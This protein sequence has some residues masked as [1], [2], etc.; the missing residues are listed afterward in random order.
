VERCAS[1]HPS[2]VLPDGS[3]DVDG[4]SHV[5]GT[6]DVFTSH[7][8]N[9]RAPEV[10]GLAAKD[11]LRS[12]QTCHG[13]DFA[14][15]TSTVSCN[16]CHGGAQW[17]TNCTF[18]HGDRVTGLAAPPRGPRGETS[19]STLAVGAHTAHVSAGGM[20]RAFSCDV[21]HA[22]P[23]NLAHIDGDSSPRFGTLAR[24]GG[25]APQWSPATASCATTY[26]HGDTLSGGTV[27]APVWTRVDGTQAACGTCHS[28]PPP[29][30]HPDSSSCG[31][32]HTGYSES[33]VNAAVHVDG[34]VQVSAAACGAC[35]SIPPPPPHVQSQVCGSCHP[36]YTAT[37]VVTRTHIDGQVQAGSGACGS[38]HLIPPAAPHP[39]LL[40]CGTCHAG[41]TASSANEATHMDGQIQAAATCGSC[42]GIPPAAP[43]PQ[44]TTCGTCHTGY[45]ATAAN[46]ATHL[47]GRV[48]A[49]LICGTCHAIPPG[50]PHTPLTTCGTCHPGY[51]PSSANAATHMDGQ[52]QANVTCGSCHGI[53]P[54][55]PH[56][57]ITTCGTCHP[58]Y[59]ATAVNAATH[60]DGRVQSDMQ[61]G[62]CHSIPPSS[63]SHEE[64]E[65]EGISC[66]TC[67]AGFTRTSAGP[68]H[69]NGRIEVSAPGWSPSNTTC[70]NACHG[71]ERWDD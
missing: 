69:L 49:N 44:I 28:T 23:T 21:C 24:T 16:A 31:A 64:H 41:Y 61:C 40:T 13:A 3:L 62:A 34:T 33:S 8:A 14:G 37:S 36:G 15:G 70:A 52:V 50:P 17:Q 54:A 12:C 22:V 30:P 32:C 11:D 18:C 2:T 55:L 68:G 53:P 47:D 59:T 10:H 7:P 42:H 57:A 60:A 67:H 58:G 26:C 48:Q 56:P 35:H 46:E 43:H 1:C 6:L 71:T 38:C 63:R 51:T 39:Q 65:E 25:S 9:W 20:A 29:A 27:T 45:T 5:N 66:A 19:P 4:G